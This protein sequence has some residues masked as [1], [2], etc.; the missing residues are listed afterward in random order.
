MD[1]KTGLKGIVFDNSFDNLPR[2]PSF[3]LDDWFFWFPILEEVTGRDE[4]SPQIRIV[5]KPGWGGDVNYDDK[6]QELTIPIGVVCGIYNQYV[7]QMGVEPSASIASNFTVDDLYKL[8]ELYHNWGIEKEPWIFNVLFQSIIDYKFSSLVN[9]I[10]SALNREKMFAGDFLDDLFKYLITSET[11]SEVKKSQLRSVIKEE[12]T[13]L[14][15]YDSDECL[16]YD[17][18]LSFAGEDRKIAGHL[19]RSLLIEGVRVFYDEF[20]KGEIWGKKLTQHF[21]DV[22]GPK[23]R[24]VMILISKHYPIKDWTDF[25]FD[26]AKGEAKKRKTEFIL[27][28]RLDNTKILGIHQDVAYL[29]YKIEG[30]EGIVDAVLNKLSEN[31]KKITKGIFVTTLGVNFEDLVEKEIIS[32]NDCKDYPRTCDKLEADLKVKLD[33][34][35]IGEYHF[36]EPSDRN[37]ETLSVRIVYFWDK[38]WGLPDFTFTDY[39]DFL[40]FRPVEEIYP[41]SHKEVKSMFGVDILAKEQYKE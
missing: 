32:K 30:I 8:Y 36:T 24:F 10:S 33:K 3:W 26:I 7:E 15:E 40:E 11:V 38:S 25:E 2:R 27:P 37:G 12:P 17:I 39:W 13:P 1:T 23:A 21:Q 18:A 31:G 28:V 5:V 35:S 22:Y 34:S 29:N 9:F 19:A 20:Y 14:Q 6:A 4:P 41:N 16:V